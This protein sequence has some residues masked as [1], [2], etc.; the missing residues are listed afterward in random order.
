MSDKETQKH[1]I[2]CELKTKPYKGNEI[3]FRLMGLPGWHAVDEHHIIKRWSLIDFK[4]AL[5]FVNKIGEIAEAE[6]HHPDISLSWGRVEVT[7]FT[8]SIDGLSEND[9]IMAELI[10]GVGK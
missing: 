3:T 4:S 8:H 5:A 10:E 1:C 9:F 6:G 2:P 7:L